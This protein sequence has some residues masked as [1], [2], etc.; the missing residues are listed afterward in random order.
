MTTAFIEH[1]RGELDGLKA[2]G[3]YKT[4]RVITSPQSASITVADGR[5]VLNCAGIDPSDRAIEGMVAFV[6]KGIRVSSALRRG[7]E[8][9]IAA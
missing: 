7:D 5:E 3:L 1:I 6:R 8:A 2:S 9:D 4:E